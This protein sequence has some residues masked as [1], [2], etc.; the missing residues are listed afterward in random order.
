MSDNSDIA[1][2]DN[3][4]VEGDSVYK[5]DSP[6]HYSSNNVSMAS[7]EDSL[8]EI[9]E[10]SLKNPK[11]FGIIKKILRQCNPDLSHYYPKC[12]ESYICNA[13]IPLLTRKEVDDLFRQEIGLR[14]IFFKSLENYRAENCLKEEKEANDAE[15]EEKNEPAAKPKHFKEFNGWKIMS[16]KEILENYEGEYIIEY[17]EKHE[18]LTYSL[19][20]KI[21][22]ILV[23]F[24]IKNQI[25][26]G[27]TDFPKV[28][29]MITSYF[30]DEDEEFFYNH[31][32]GS[33]KGPQ[34]IL[35]SRWSN[36][37]Y[38]LRLHNLMGY[39]NKKPST[40]NANRTSTSAAA[41][42]EP[43]SNEIDAINFLKT[44]KTPWSVVEEKWEETFPIRKKDFQDE[45]TMKEIL[46]KFPIL[47]NL[48]LGKL[49]ISIDFKLIVTSYKNVNYD[50]SAVWNTYSKVILSQVYQ[51]TKLK[52]FDIGEIENNEDLLDI[53]CF[54]AL[55]HLVPQGTISL[56]SDSDGEGDK[57]T[58][59]SLAILQR[60]RPKQQTTD[61][62]K[63]APK[64]KGKSNSNTENNGKA[65]KIKNTRHPSVNDSKKSTLLLISH[66]QGVMEEIEK[67]AVSQQDVKKLRFHPIMA[68]VLNE[69]GLPTKFYVL[70]ENLLYETENFRNCLETYIKSFWVF[71][72]KYP[73]EGKRACQFLLQLCFN[74]KSDDRSLTTIIKDLQHLNKTNK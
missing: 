40:R 41:S 51:N 37:T 52:E 65:L 27:R 14:G 64:K 46:S 21:V 10:E 53:K 22:H 1:K 74:I 38:H 68:V 18:H 58:E 42:L 43:T 2:N 50:F 31:P 4:V 3:S 54:H 34:G 73:K 35:F 19:R 26:L 30:K 24:F 7:L 48:I 72:L 57:N 8:T 66:G 44:N 45:K 67:Y 13:S 49:L 5:K 25:W 36:Q 33:R 20:K 15:Y 59:K 69:R 62:P 47:G 55:H 29:Q 61:K 16:I 9:F 60:K 17:Y 23:R 32:V 70:V 56:D 12:K 63:A 39:K 28:T 71:N 6:S 11:G